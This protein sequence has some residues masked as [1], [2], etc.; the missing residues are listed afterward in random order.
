L[1]IEK[2]KIERWIRD[3]R[4]AGILRDDGFN[5]A[6]AASGEGKAAELLY[7]HS[8]KQKGTAVFALL[9]M[10]GVARSS[11][12]CVWDRALGIFGKPESFPEFEGETVRLEGAGRALFAGLTQANAEALRRALP[13]TAPSPLA[14]REI[15][16]GVGDRLGVA[17][18]GHLRVM[19]RYRAT[20]VLAQ[21]SV[22]ELDLTG[23]N[24]QQVLDASSWAVFQEG[25][26]QPWGADGD[27]LKTEEWVRTAVG[28]GY[29]MITADVSDYIRKDFATADAVR[30]R[31]AYSSLAAS[32]RRR[33]EKR[34]LRLEAV[35]DT[36]EKISFTEEV[37][38][39]TA[40]VY[41]EAIEHGQRLYRAGVE[42]KG[43]GSFDFEL[44]VD[45]TETPTTPEAHL[46]V[47]LEAKEAGMKISSLAPRFVGEFQKGIDYIGDL[48]E[49]ERTLATHAALARH[50]GYRISVHSGSD[51]FSAFPIVGELTRGRF[52]IKT[53]GTNWLEAVKI[54]AVAEPVLYRRL[55]QAAL[56]RF[57]KATSYYHVTTNLDNVPPLK[58]LA[59]S[60]LPGLFDNPDGRQLIHITY[61]ELLR[62]PEI[63]GPFFEALDN[64][65]EEYWQALDRHIGRHLQTLGVAAAE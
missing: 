14:D 22:R 8:V 27:H 12:P 40:L 65:I 20:P 17:G 46:F 48:K 53:A 56:D 35:L 26:E 32:Y 42:V 39:R 36:G 62:D 18:A 15:T 2:T 55:H 33:I 45:E 7:A 59:D 34:Y 3:A 24:Y 10:P 4:A 47:A 58:G 52:H 60:D 49:F 21:Q 63:G 11:A 23:R 38:A 25:Y 13:F 6:A 43:E 28:I 37:L 9:K 50:L 61:G 19:K 5:S 30:I 29:T 41:G 57:G 16:F 51:K 31:D 44:S 1:K 54:M 64:H